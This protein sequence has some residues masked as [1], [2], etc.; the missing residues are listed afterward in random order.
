VMAGGDYERLIQT[1]ESN[2]MNRRPL[3]TGMPN[4][5]RHDDEASGVCEWRS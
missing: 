4:D 1:M 3:A 2:G 5:M